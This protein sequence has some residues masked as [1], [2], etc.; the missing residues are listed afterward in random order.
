M[1][2]FLV[3]ETGNGFTGEIPPGSAPFQML[4]KTRLFS[5]SVP[6]GTTLK[7]LLKE[8]HPKEKKSSGDEIKLLPYH[9][10]LRTDRHAD[11]LCNRPALC[12][13]QVSN[14]RQVLHL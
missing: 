9:R 6:P 12:S 8:F 2:F 10:N 14:R 5:G 1:G 4:Y 13:Q 11:I 3:G 7:F